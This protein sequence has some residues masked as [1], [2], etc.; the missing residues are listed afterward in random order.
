MIHFCFLFDI[1]HNH[2]HDEDS[3]MAEWKHFLKCIS[4][5]EN[6]LITGRDGLKVIEIIEAARQSSVDKAQVKVIYDI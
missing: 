3:Y 1:C 2:N 6:P 4:G 5:D